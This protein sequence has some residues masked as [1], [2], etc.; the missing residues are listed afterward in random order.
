MSGPGNHENG[1][2]QNSG[3]SPPGEFQ[4][5]MQ[6]DLSHFIKPFPS[7]P[8]MN[9][10]RIFP[11]PGLLL[12]T[13]K[14]EKVSNQTD[15]YNSHDQVFH[16]WPPEAE[17]KRSFTSASRLWRLLRIDPLFPQGKESFSAVR[18]V[19][20]DNV[21]YSFRLRIDLIGLGGHF[22]FFLGQRFSLIGHA[23]VDAAKTFGFVGGQKI[24][25]KFQTPV[26]A[27]HAFDFPYPGFLKQIQ[28]ILQ[29]PVDATGTFP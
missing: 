18:S 7:H 23:P 2:L 10:T 9:G 1:G 13:H 14:R 22:E 5:E 15:N 21:I 12:G 11:C 6:V 29:T 20:R 19:R 17:E 26:D 16:P 27:A 3:K 8:R 24:S 25:L 4:T 28:L